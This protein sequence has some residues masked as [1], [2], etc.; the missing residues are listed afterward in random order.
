MK[1]D[2]IWDFEAFLNLG[3]RRVW[4]KYE[5]EVIL[6]KRSVARRRVGGKE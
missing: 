4:K 3:F 1:A 5:G 6:L 2:I